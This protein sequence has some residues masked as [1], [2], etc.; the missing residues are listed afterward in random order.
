MTSQPVVEAFY[1]PLGERDDKPFGVFPVNDIVF[2]PHFHYTYELVFV[3][4]GTVMFLIN[5]R[6][7][8]ITEGDV[9]ILTPGD[10]HGYETIGSSRIIILLFIESEFL[11]LKSIFSTCAL[12]HSVIHYPASGIVDLKQRLD[13]ASDENAKRLCYKG[14]IN[15]LFFDLLQNVELIR[16]TQHDKENTLRKVL[17]FVRQHFDKGINLEET[18]RELGLSSS[19]LSRSFK[20]AIG[21]TFNE[22]VNRLRVE[23]SK[24]LLRRDLAPIYDIA[25]ECGFGNQRS[26]NR[27]FKH[28]MAMTP[29][30]Y[31]TMREEN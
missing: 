25:A 23:K 15:N 8:E 28:F 16:Q 5:S 4:S 7:I 10:I 27:S 30:E 24:R 18:A 9:A 12:K 14:Y 6:K 13:L 2:P 1:Q 17:V 20:K 19:H 21:C 31:R 26:F 29:L 22:Y 3:L 11:E